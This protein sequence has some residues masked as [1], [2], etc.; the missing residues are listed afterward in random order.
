MVYSDPR[1]FSVL[2]R[3]RPKP[4]TSVTVMPSTPLA[5]QGL[6]DVVELVRLDDRG[7]EFDHD[8]TPGSRV[9]RL[10]MVGGGPCSWMSMPSRSPSSETRRMSAFLHAVH[11]GHGDD[12][13]GAADDGVAPDLRPQLLAVPPPQN[14]PFDVGYRTGR[15]RTGRR[16]TC[17]RCRP[18]PCTAT[19]PI[20]SSIA[21]VF[22]EVDAEDDDD[23]ADEA[24]DHRPERVDPVTRRGDGHE[25]A[26]EPV[27]RDA[28]VPFLGSRVDPGH[29]GQTS[30]SRGECGVG[31]HS[32]DARGVDRRQRAAGVEPVP[33][34]PQDH[35]AD[36][37][38]RQVVARW[39][40]AAVALELAAEAWAEHDR[41]GEG[42]HAAHRV[43]DGRAGEVTDEHAVARRSAASRPDP[44]PSG[45]G[46]G[47]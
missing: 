28:H 19:A 30:G 38:D 31:G 12:E 22:D 44:T 8:P 34:E 2:P 21:K 10:R 20:G 47:R 32:A 4:R 36:G 15:W 40:P 39:Q 45:R 24:D 5:E 6:L 37:G 43:H 14:R 16:P 7:D 18:M 23:A 42:D 17:P 26:E 41:A 29:R 25:P 11:D 3:W 35:A 33:A 1:K 27:D 9:G 46:S 13:G